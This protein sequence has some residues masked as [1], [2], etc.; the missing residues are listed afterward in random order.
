MVIEE[1][2]RYLVASLLLLTGCSY[3]Q[4]VKFNENYFETKY[5]RI[6]KPGPTWTWR[7]GDGGYRGPSIY[8]A[9]DIVWGRS[10]PGR[11]AIY[12]MRFKQYNDFISKR[13]FLKKF[14][15]KT[16]EGATVYAIEQFIS[17]RRNPPL[18]LQILSHGQIRLSDREAI[19]VVCK[20]KDITVENTTPIDILYKFIF[21]NLGVDWK[22]RGILG[23]QLDALVLWY[24][25]P[26]EDF[27]VGIDD[28]E[29]M[30]QSLYIKT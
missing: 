17:W 25:S 13:E 6:S 12:V 16:F 21:I 1:V 5:Y 11:N 20:I 10:I 18:E 19:E 27:D 30:T 2:Q 22:S 23:S 15:A 28:F 26:V 29:K 8:C 4:V 3:K 9:E 14:N 24:A 7:Y